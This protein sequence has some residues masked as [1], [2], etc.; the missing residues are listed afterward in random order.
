MQSSA[1]VK[2]AVVDERPAGQLLHFLSEL[3]PVAELYVFGGH[4]MH[5]DSVVAFVSV[6]YLPAPQVLHDVWP[7]SS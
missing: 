1:E 5:F 4:F 7:I 2:P 6:P 3:R